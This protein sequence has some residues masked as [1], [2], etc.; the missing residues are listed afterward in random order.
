[1]RGLATIV[2]EVG[3]VMVAREELMAR[4]GGKVGGNLIPC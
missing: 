4:G 3:L 1:M 2:R